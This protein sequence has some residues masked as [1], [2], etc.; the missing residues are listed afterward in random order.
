VQQQSWTS[1]GILY[2][3]MILSL[4]LK[5]LAMAEHKFKMGQV[6]YFHPKKS[7]LVSDAPPGP[8][9]IIRRLPA[10]DG[11]FRGKH[12]NVLGSSSA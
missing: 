3:A 4:A 7:R 1:L 12:G 6:V 10:I 2:S 11:E 8:Y 5:V 9:Q